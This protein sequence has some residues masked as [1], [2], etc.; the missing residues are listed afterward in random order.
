MS[1]SRVNPMDAYL[2]AS[3]ADKPKKRK[4]T[5]AE[6]NDAAADEFLKNLQARRENQSPAIPEPKPAPQQAPAFGA[7][8]VPQRKFGKNGRYEHLVQLNILVP[9]DMRRELQDIVFE[10]KRAGDATANISAFCRS[11]IQ[12]AIEEYGNE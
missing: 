9:P 8:P 12:R 4:M 1:K 11:A 2:G 7:D 3:E 10:Q 5:S 6:R